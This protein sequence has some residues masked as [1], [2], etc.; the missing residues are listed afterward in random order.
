MCD[1][2]VLKRVLQK[3]DIRMTTTLFLVCFCYFLFVAPIAVANIVDYHVNKPEVHL[4]TH[5]LYWLQ[6]SLNFVIYAARSEQYRK[7]YL[8]FLNQV[9]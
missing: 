1:R 3:R 9:T 5:C 6:Y 2:P 4:G 7:A 8:F